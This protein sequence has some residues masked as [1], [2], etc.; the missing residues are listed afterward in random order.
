MEF[1][2]GCEEADFARRES[3]LLK[4]LVVENEVFG[5]RGET[6]THEY[7]ICNPAP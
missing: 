5:A 2:S 1:K 3:P 7:R 4:L 6:R